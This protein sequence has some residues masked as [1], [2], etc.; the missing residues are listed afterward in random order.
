LTKFRGQFPRKGPLPFRYVFVITFIL[1]AAFTFQGLWIINKGIKPTL[2]A[3]AESYTRQIATKAINDAVNRRLADELDMEKLVVTTEDDKGN[4]TSVGWNSEMM[5][6][7]LHTATYNAQDYLDKIQR[8]EVPPSGLPP[9][10]EV[11]MDSSEKSGIIYK[12]PLGQATNNALLANLGPVVPIR[13]SVIGDV[14]SDIKYDVK[15]FGIN[16]A[17]IQIYVYL[18]VN[19]RI[20]IPFATDTA[21]ITTDIP[22]HITSIN[23]PVPDVFLNGDVNGDGSSILPPINTD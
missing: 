8:G 1:F 17:L 16:N 7:V 13:F 12:V 23:G 15:E 5:H 10:V 9:E 11:E 22:I 21:T 19:V 20:V 18:E 4:I 14:S 2:M 6:K 3:V